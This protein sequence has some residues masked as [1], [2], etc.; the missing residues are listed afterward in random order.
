MCL[1]K[2]CLVNVIIVLFT[3]YPPPAEKETY[4]ATD[5]LAICA[6]GRVGHSSILKMSM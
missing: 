6:R 1:Y 3:I 2:Q 5:F 4:S